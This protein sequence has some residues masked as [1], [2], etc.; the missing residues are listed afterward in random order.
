MKI[1]NILSSGYRKMYQTTIMS[2]VALIC[3]ASCNSNK[4]PETIIINPLNVI[5]REVFLSEFAD[6]IIYI[7]L[8]NHILFQNPNRIK[9][10][11]NRIII[12]AFPA[13]LLSYDYNGS[14]INKVGSTGRGP[15]EYMTGMYFTV[16]N[17]KKLIY[18]YDNKRILVYNIDG[19]YVSTIQV[20]VPDYVG[21]IFFFNGLIYLAGGPRFDFD[22]VVYDT[23]GN[24]VSYKNNELP[25][26]QSGMG[27]SMGFTLSPDGL[28]YWNS[29]ND[30]IFLIQDGSFKHT[31][32]FAQGEFRLPFADL[33]FQDFGKYFHPIT[34]LATGNYIF[35]VYLLD[36]IIHTSY[37]NKENGR[38]YLIGSG[39]DMSSLNRPGILNDL[40]N[41]PK[42][43]PFFNYLE[44]NREYLIG[45][46]HAYRLKAHVESEA[47]KNSTP[48]YPEKKKELEELANRLDENDNPVLMLVKLKE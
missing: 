35:F 31:N 6:E 41:G 25:R 45:W 47:F 8:D 38:H 10:V 22:W 33:P 36:K 46:I 1:E 24:M 44:N 5:E 15:G 29:Y 16:N 30:T 32:Y 13:G 2:I 11:N 17:A 40:D 23:S 3:L 43:A 28:N 48:K 9:T 34:I 19:S 14:F 27:S 7:P 12:S 20:D 26:F 4:T 42:F 21:D 39:A 37:I 18:V